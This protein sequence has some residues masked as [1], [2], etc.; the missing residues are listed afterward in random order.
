MRIGIRWKVLGG[1]LAIVALIVTVAAVTY[2]KTSAIDASIDDLEDHSIPLLVSAEKLTSNTH[3][4]VASLMGYLAF[5]KTEMIEQFKQ[6]S[7]ENHRLIEEMNKMES[8]EEE[9]NHI[10]NI[11]ARLS[12]YEKVASE[13]IIPAYQ[14][15]DRSALSQGLNKSYPMIPGVIEAVDSL[16]ELGE[17]R[18]GTDIDRS[19]ERAHQ[20]IQLSWILALIAAGLSIVAALL[21]SN[22]ITRPLRKLAESARLVAEGDL[23]Q[24]VEV[25]SGDEIEDLGHSFNRMVDELRTLLEKVQHTSKQ[26]AAISTEIGASTEETTKT[27]ERV[28]SAMNAVSEGTTEQVQL[29]D[30]AFDDVA[31]MSAATHEITAIVYRA[32]QA[33]RKTMELAQ[34]GSEA[35]DHTV[36]KM[37]EIRDAVGHTAQVIKGLAD[38]SQAIGQIVEAITGIAG[39]TNLLALNAA[40]EAAR[41]GEQGR[42]FAVVAD[43]VR[44]LAEESAQSAEQIRHLI[45]EIRAEMDRAVEAMSRGTGKVAEGTT[46]ATKTGEAF[47]QITQSLR[48]TNELIEEIGEA[49]EQQAVG[50]SE[51]LIV[52]VVAAV[53]Q[54]KKLADVNAGSSQEVAA[55]TEEQ[56]AAM[57]E[58]NGTVQ[59]VSQIAGQLA[60]ALQQFRT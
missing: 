59:H 7:E 11:S 40:I 4:E 22:G 36:G 18:M 2:F 46:V 48:E 28:A 51:Q 54:I 56:T 5:G 1:Y 14:R 31:K 16:K 27:V 13:E 45:G 21:L 37:Q 9:R 34:S 29:V 26:L 19:Q 24:K 38:K 57:E 55:A 43:E 53:E 20:A 39:Q 25:H 12:V 23:T 17:K 42:G 49:A 41:A 58:I 30:K 15:G 60:A 6:A 52:S 50:S 8:T 44:K 35:V 33:S 10:R 32:G 47:Q 3:L